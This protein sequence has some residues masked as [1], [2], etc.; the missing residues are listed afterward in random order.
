[1]RVT[2]ILSFLFVFAAFLM[3]A[4]VCNASDVCFSCHDRD[5]YRNKVVHEPVAK[6]KCTLCHNPH[7]AKYKAL[8]QMQVDVL[9]F[10]CHPEEKKRF[11]EN[12]VH[13][14][15][16]NG[17]CL[18]CHDPHVSGLK[19]L[20]RGKLAQRCFE[21]HPQIDQKN[22]VV[23][24]PFASGECTACHR[25][26]T[27]ENFQLLIVAP[28]KICLKCHTGESV[29]AKHAN[30]PATIINCLSCHNPHS[31]NRKGLIRNVLHEPFKDGCADCHEKGRKQVGTA[32]CLECHDELS[33]NARTLH[34]H[35]T[36][37]SGNSCV[38]C[39]S[40][41]AADR[42]SLLKGSEKGVC[43]SCHQDT[44]ERYEA[45]SYV[46]KDTAP[47]CSTC[48]MVHGSDYMALLKDGGQEV[49]V[50]CH[51]RHS[52]FTHP[53][54]KGVFDP[55]TGQQMTC[56]SCHNPHGTDYSGNLRLSGEKQ[57]CNQCHKGY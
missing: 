19:G 1:M 12:K 40:P 57:L 38:N 56:I 27:A 3:T 25:P 8:L 17:E 26:H 10:S 18:A 9:C 28:Q 54:G 36:E 46:H 7:V 33:R 47:P 35:M 51:E 2:K 31:S 14:P 22:K 15:V 21:C 30:Y 39:H 11:Q 24:K 42:K 44:V 45:K 23:H 34:N 52:T 6:G 29:Q 50:Q 13:R 4:D 32:K 49:C 20:I 43:R 5:T 53:I 41:H 48:H 37:S 16:R 55:R